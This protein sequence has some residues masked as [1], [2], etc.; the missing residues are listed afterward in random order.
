MEGL[1]SVFGELELTSYGLNKE[2]M[3]LWSSLNGRH[4]RVFRERRRHHVMVKSKWTIFSSPTE[5]QISINHDSPSNDQP[6]RRRL[7]QPHRS[8]PID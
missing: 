1:W 6:H 2:S 4:M 3:V 8:T 5:A 7:R